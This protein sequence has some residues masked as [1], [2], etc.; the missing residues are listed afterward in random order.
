[1]TALCKT[2]FETKIR[3]SGLVVTKS[4]PKPIS[5]QRQ[6]QEVEGKFPLLKW[7]K[8]SF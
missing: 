4:K 8:K 7:E 5:S 1:M 2:V 6:I 3:E